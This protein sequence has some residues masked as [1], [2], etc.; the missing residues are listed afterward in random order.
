MGELK[1]P[2][3]LMSAISYEDFATRVFCSGWFNGTL[4]GE[5]DVLRGNGFYFPMTALLT[6]VS[7][8]SSYF[9][10]MTL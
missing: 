4:W 3:D 9:L 5:G 1:L 10:S 2:V 7:F 6:L 8:C